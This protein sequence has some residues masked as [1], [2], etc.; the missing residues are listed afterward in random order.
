M[1]EVRRLLSRKASR[2]L[3]HFVV[4]GAAAGTLGSYASYAMRSHS[5]APAQGAAAA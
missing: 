1:G 3:V 5:E 4:L 2:F